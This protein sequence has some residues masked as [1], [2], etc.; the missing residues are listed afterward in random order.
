MAL[1]AGD[2]DPWE[3]GMQLPFQASPSALT[4]ISFPLCKKCEPMS[5]LEGGACALLIVAMPIGS[6]QQDGGAAVRLLVEVSRMTADA[7]E[8]RTHAVDETALLRNVSHEPL[9]CEMCEHL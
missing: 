5:M 3:R 6:A 4:N 9:R 2:R 7:S 1:P 8:Y